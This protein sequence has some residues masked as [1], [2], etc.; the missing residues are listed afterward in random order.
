MM[1]ASLFP[2]AAKIA[3]ATALFIFAACDDATPQAPEEILPDPYAQCAHL[4]FI[5]LAPGLDGVTVELLRPS[6]LFTK[7]D[8]LWLPG[9]PEMRSISPQPLTLSAWTP[10]FHCMPTHDGQL[11]VSRQTTTIATAAIDA[12]QATKHLAMLIA[13]AGDVG[14][15]VRRLWAPSTTDDT[16]LAYVSFFHGAADLGRISI[17]LALSN[18]TAAAQWP[19]APFGTS[20]LDAPFGTSSLDAPTPLEPGIYAVG[21]TTAN[22]EPL[23]IVAPKTLVLQP[24]YH[25]TLIVAPREHNQ[26][27]PR[28]VIMSDP[29]HGTPLQDEPPATVAN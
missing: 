10:R 25:V 8:H 20:S 14:L 13:S 16:N 27:T 23:T 6:H 12:P 26:A 1:E 22:E 7:V 18:G 9:E 29:L 2:H 21:I 24:G 28:L 3:C 19:N 5:N 15:E 17:R 11:T 4:R